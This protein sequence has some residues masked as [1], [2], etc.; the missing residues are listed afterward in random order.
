M[1]RAASAAP[2]SAPRSCSFMPAGIAC[3][4]IGRLLLR[5]SCAP[6]FVTPQCVR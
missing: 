2:W 1:A 4:G 3:A 6:S 5:H